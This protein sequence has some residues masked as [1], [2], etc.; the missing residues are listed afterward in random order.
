MPLTLLNT[1]S[2]D[3]NY[4]RLLLFGFADSGKTRMAATM[5]NPLLATSEG[6]VLSLAGEDVP[7][8]NL[9]SS[10][11]FWE[12]IAALEQTPENRIATFGRPIDSV[13]FD[14][15]DEIQR[16]FMRERLRSVNRDTPERPDYMW[17]VERMRE[18][19]ARMRDLP[20]HVVITCHVDQVDPD[21]GPAYL[22]PSLAGA[23]KGEITS[24][25]DVAG[26]LSSRNAVD[27]ETNTVVVQRFLSCTN[28]PAMRF[29]KDHSGRMP[30]EFPL[31]FADDF[32]RMWDTTRPGLVTTP[33]VLEAAPEVDALRAGEPAPELAAPAAG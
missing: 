17:I 6:L 30:Y 14:T 1:S 28:T 22:R 15:F 5:P 10:A 19:A 29:L 2:P 20:M 4:L 12:L 9:N 16:M 13:S 23:M 26:I 8:V 24:Y 21:D 11:D 3:H 7:F 25:V 31:N 32:Q 33:P 27:P 18:V